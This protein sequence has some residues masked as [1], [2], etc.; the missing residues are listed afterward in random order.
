MFSTDNVYL[1]V[2]NIIG[3]VR[4]ILLFA[5]YISDKSVN[6]WL[7]ISFYAL[8]QILDGLDGHAA[9]Y[10]NQCSELGANLD[11]IIDRATSIVLL[12]KIVKDTVGYLYLK[13]FMLLF[14][15]LDIFSHWL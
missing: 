8:S 14:L 10:L 9:R 7:Q 12:F 2:P 13:H 15:L 5:F 4:I 3:Y 1:F 6:I 11:M